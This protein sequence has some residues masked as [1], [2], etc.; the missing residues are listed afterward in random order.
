MSEI[1]ADD[2]TERFDLLQS[3]PEKYLALCNEYVRQHPSDS[4]GYFSR[5]QVWERLG[6]SDMA[7][8]DLNGSLDIEEHPA[9]LCARGILLGKAGQYGEAIKDFN[10][11]EELDP[12]G[13]APCGAAL[14]RANCHARL[15]NEEAALADCALLPDDHW[16]PNLFGAPGGTKAEIAARLREIVEEAR[17]SQG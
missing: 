6:R 11:L 16:T 17:Q 8:R 13:F 1:T 12:K 14:F 15:G 7:I 5:H 9:T 3:E 4:H 2:L 10:R